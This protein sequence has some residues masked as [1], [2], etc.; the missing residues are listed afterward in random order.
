MNFDQFRL[1]MWPRNAWIREPGIRIYVRR[2]IPGRE[3]DIDLAN[4]E[5]TTPG[6]GALTAFLDRYE[7]THRFYIEQIVNPRLGD[8]FARRGYQWVDN[9]PLD[10]RKPKA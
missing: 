6:K 1:G 10:M 9:R 3:T 5:A 8:F 4:M 7:P 2:S